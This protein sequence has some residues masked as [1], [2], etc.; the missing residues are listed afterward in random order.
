M[1]G[2]F[3]WARRFMQK[4]V[5][6]L[7]VVFALLLVVGVVVSPWVIFLKG[8]WR[9]ILRCYLLPYPLVLLGFALIMALVNRRELLTRL[10]NW[11]KTEKLRETARPDVR[12]GPRTRRLHSN[13]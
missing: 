10:R 12:F 2:M 1:T 5:A 7:R 3:A 13:F 11:R 4:L 9:L 8:G 6:S